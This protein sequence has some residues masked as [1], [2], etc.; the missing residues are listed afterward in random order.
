MHPSAGDREEVEE[1]WWFSLVMR[2]ILLD[3]WEWNKKK[4][5]FGWNTPCIQDKEH[6]FADSFIS[7]LLNF[8]LM[9][10]TG[11]DFKLWSG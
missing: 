10:V 3:F 1:F 6:R 2:D 8:R 11:V 7:M 9:D 5:E 4:K